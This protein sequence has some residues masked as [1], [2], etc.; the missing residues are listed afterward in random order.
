MGQRLPATGDAQLPAK[1]IQTLTGE[2]MKAQI[3]KALPKH[4]GPDRFMRLALTMLR[5]PDLT[6]C[7]PVSIMSSV[8]EA[9]QA[10]L[11]LDGV[12]GHGYLVPYRDKSSGQK[13]AKFIPGYRGLITLAG[14]CEGVS[15][16]EAATVYE[17]DEFWFQ[18]GDSPVLHHK[19]TRDVS[20]RGDATAYYAVVVYKSGQRKWEVMEMADV[21]KIKDR[22]PASKSSYSPWSHPDDR[23]EMGKKTVIKRVLKTAGLT[24]EITRYVAQ[25]E[26]YEAGVGTRFVDAE[27]TTPRGGK[28]LKESIQSERRKPQSDPEPEGTLGG[29][30]GEDRLPSDEE[31]RDAE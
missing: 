24:A 14:R 15:H 25:E 27:V 18:K 17:G 12:L 23:H 29:Y 26:Y 8:M 22:S 6:Q 31:I 3:A 11:E 21:E 30:P 10:G 13:E 2:A 5:R 9:A 1:V 28:A 4:L 20:K 7:T 16:I 19:P